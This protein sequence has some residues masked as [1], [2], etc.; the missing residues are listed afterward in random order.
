MY[1]E[2]VPQSLGLVPH[3]TRLVCG[4][5]AARETKNRLQD[6]YQFISTNERFVQDENLQACKAS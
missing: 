3:R 4:W 2:Y 6:L 5:P 1:D